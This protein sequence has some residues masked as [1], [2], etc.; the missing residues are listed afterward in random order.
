MIEFDLSG[1]HTDR[2]NNLIVTL[3]QCTFSPLVVGSK[4]C[5]RV[6]MVVMDVVNVT[7][8]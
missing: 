3:L 8:V 4:L 1:Y 5:V 2:C 6:Q 7:I